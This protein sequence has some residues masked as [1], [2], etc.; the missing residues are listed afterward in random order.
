MEKTKKESGDIGNPVFNTHPLN[1]SLKTTS[2]S[3]SMHG[4]LNSPTTPTD[5]IFVK[6]TGDY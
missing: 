5:N 1:T 3:T 2:M 6:S 4:M